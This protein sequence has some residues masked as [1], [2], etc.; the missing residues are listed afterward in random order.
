MDLAYVVL[1][2]VDR[3]DLLDGGAS[4]VARTVQ[5][6]RALQ[7]RLLIETLVGDFAGAPRSSRHACVRDGRPDVFAHNVEVVPRL[8]RTHARCALLV[9]A[10]DR[11]LAL[12]ARGRRASHQELR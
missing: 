11:G 4:H 12:G 10:L 9:G 7:P 1:T 6:I 2:M 5:R 8:Q 3:D